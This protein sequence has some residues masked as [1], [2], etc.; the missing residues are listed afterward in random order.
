MADN[1]LFFLFPNKRLRGGEACR[2]HQI[3]VSK[4]RR[5]CSTRE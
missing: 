3:P 1:H 5:S 4:R 2:E